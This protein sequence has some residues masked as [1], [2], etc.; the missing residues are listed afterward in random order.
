LT[1]LGRVLEREGKDADAEPFLRESLSL[2]KDARANRNVVVLGAMR[3]LATV[4]KKQG[5]LTEAESL[6]REAIEIA[7]ANPSLTQPDLPVFLLRLGSILKE[8]ERPEE[9]VPVYR[10]GIALRIESLPP[11]SPQIAE[12]L[13]S[14]A[15]LL[16]ALGK[17]KDGQ[18]LCDGIGKGYAEALEARR[19]ADG[20]NDVFAKAVTS[21][22]SMFRSAGRLAD[23]ER[24]F[25]LA[26]DVRRHTLGEASP[27]VSNSL[28]ALSDILRAQGRTADAEAVWRQS[29]EALRKSSRPEDQAALVKRQENLSKLKSDGGEPTSRKAKSATRAARSAAASEATR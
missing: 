17:V 16:Q 15:A 24:R 21:V 4:L 26:L 14:Y 27:E 10:E 19:P 29:I 6:F 2:Y 22:G 25:L 1:T 23:A 20:D 18:E 3:A 5:K 9:A 13:A 7:R 11:G 28:R 12:E 8:E